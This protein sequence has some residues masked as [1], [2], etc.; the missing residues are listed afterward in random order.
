[1]TMSKKAIIAEARALRAYFYFELIREFQFPYLKNP[2]AP[3]VPIYTTPTSDTTRGNPR[4]TVQQVYDQIDDDINYAVQNIGTT[5]LLKDQVNS[6]V[7]W[8]MAAR[9]YLEQ[10]RWADAE[11]AAKN[12]I[13]GH[14]LDPT[15]Y[16][17]NYNGLT[18]TEV[19]WG[20]PQTTSNGGQSLYYGTP[21]SFFE[22]TGEGYD[23]FWMSKELV[24]HFTTTDIRNTFFVYDPDPSQA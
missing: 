8:G 3:G 2:A 1:M 24:E 6:N 12:A 10:G 7:A 20:F 11:N 13:Q 17:D 14:S 23:A 16:P 15:G 9:I 18:S 21:S 22:Q 5:Q 4:G 19:L